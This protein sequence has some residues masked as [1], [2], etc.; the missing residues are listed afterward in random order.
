MA[1]Y[2]LLHDRDWA[3]RHP[4][5][6]LDIF[7]ATLVS[8]FE[9]V[10]KYW[11]GDCLEWGGLHGKIGGYGRLFIGKQHVAAHRIAYLVHYGHWPLNAL[12]H[13][14]NPPCV[15]P[16]HLFNGTKGDNNRDLAAKGLH[17]AMKKTHCPAGHEY[18]GD[19]LAYYAG[20]RSCKTCRRER[21]REVRARAKE[22]EFRAIM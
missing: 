7:G 6:Q 8:R 18:A 4:Y 12:H 3:L 20:V 11:V 2:R 19:N 9:A 1:Y 17:W 13:C 10:P 14:D 16:L 22:A 21:T 5:E 15:N